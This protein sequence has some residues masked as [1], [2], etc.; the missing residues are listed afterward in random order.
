[1]SSGTNEKA[2]GTA[3]PTRSFSAARAAQAGSIDS[4]MAAATDAAHRRSD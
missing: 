4:A 2:S 1:M 3:L